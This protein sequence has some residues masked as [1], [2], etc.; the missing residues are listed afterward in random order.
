MPRFPTCNATC[1]LRRGAPPARIKT[2]PLIA[3]CSSRRWKRP[4]TRRRRPT[5]RKWRGCWWKAATGCTIWPPAWRTG[6]RRLPENTAMWHR[7]SAP[8]RIRSC[9]G[10]PPSSSRTA[11]PTCRGT[12]STVPPPSAIWSSPCTATASGLAGA[13][14]SSPQPATAQTS[15]SLFPKAAKSA[16]GS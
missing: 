15:A 5:V 3:T 10:P 7:L 2:N 8:G 9:G 6:C 11:T 14:S 12:L 13:V 4:A 16:E 1:C